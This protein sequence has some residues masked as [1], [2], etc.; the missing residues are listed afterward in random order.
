MT[1]Y[2]D[3]IDRFFEFDNN[4]V[5]V[6]RK[7][8]GWYSFD[9]AFANFQG[10]IGLPM[11][12]I[13]ISGANHVGKSTLAYSLAGRLN[14]GMVLCDFESFDPSYAALILAKQGCQ[15][16]N[17][18]LPVVDDEKALEQMVALLRE[19]QYNL[20]VVDSVGAISPVSEREGH[21]GEARMGRRAQLMAQLSRRVAKLNVEMPGKAVIAI[22]HRLRKLDAYGGMYTPGGDVKD[23][24]Y[25]VRMV[26]KRKEEFEDGSY[27]V[28]GQIIKNSFG[29][30]KR[31]FW[32]FVLVGYGVHAGLTA[33]FDCFLFGKAERGRIVKMGDQKFGY[34]KNLIKA[35]KEGKN[36]VF[37]PFIEALRHDG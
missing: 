20:G 33:M 23:Y 27:I 26:L 8:T 5:A 6:V 19:E 14:L 17:R 11:T 1:D 30:R 18:V 28:E 15:V 22:N 13:E 2:N 32:L 9:R 34:L 24:L 29:Y 35:A 12:F 16:K 31:N 25:R 10:D 7:T 36:E 3:L 21:L 37:Q 4:K